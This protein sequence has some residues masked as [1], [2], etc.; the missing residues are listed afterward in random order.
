MNHTAMTAVAA[1]SASSSQSSPPWCCG[2][3]EALLSWGL[4]D[5]PPPKFGRAP[6]WLGLE[7]LPAD[8]GAPGDAPGDVFPV[9]PR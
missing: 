9:G 2:L 1:S 5:P 4:E 8:C 7:D 6:P 3:I